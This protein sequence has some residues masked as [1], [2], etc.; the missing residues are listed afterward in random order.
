MLLQGALFFVL[1]IAVTVFVLIL[2][3]P[4]IWQRMLFFVRKVM[5]SQLPVSMREIEA[6]RNFLCAQHAVQ[7]SRQQERYQLLQRINDEQRLH[8]QRNQEHLQRLHDLEGK[9]TDIEK[10]IIKYRANLNSEK[11]KVASII[12]AKGQSA[13]EVRDLYFSEK[14]VR[15]DIASYEKMLKKM[16]EKVEL[17][18]KKYNQLSQ[19]ID[20]ITKQEIHT[21]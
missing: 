9:N 15:V 5:R 16:E 2:L 3:A 11:Q 12:S 18:A 19:S 20:D 6:D 1:G 4:F 13:K 8:L 10:E 21:N 17:L 14:L 7:M